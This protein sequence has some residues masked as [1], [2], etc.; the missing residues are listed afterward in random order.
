MPFVV[1]LGCPS[2]TEDPWPPAVWM[3]RSI[4]RRKDQRAWS[5]VRQCCLGCEDTSTQRVPGRGRHP[6]RGAGHRR[7]HRRGMPLLRGV[8]HLRQGTRVHQTEGHPLR[9]R[10]NTAAMEQNQVALP[11]GLLHQHIR[12]RDDRADPGPA[13]TTGRLRIQIGT[14]VGDAARS[15][16]EVAAARMVSR[17]PTAHRRSS[18]TPRRC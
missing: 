10:P 15:V 1:P 9:T 14:A 3:L 17:P 2:V 6:T 13:H 5:R 11:G 7:G 4:R 8:L 18:N 16:A 12:H